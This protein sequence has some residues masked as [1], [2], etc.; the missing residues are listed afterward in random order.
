MHPSEARKKDAIEYRLGHFSD[1]KIIHVTRYTGR[2]ERLVATIG[3]LEERTVPPA[4]LTFTVPRDLHREVRIEALRRGMTAKEYMTALVAR[5]LRG[6]IEEKE[7]KRR[8]KKKASPRQQR[9]PNL[10]RREVLTQSS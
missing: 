2:M 10:R 4:R 7:A 8:A 5:D 1:D 3:N 6:T 9:R